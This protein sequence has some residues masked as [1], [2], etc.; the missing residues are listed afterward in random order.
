MEPLFTTKSVFNFEEYKKFNFALSGK[1]TLIAFC[2]LCPIIIVCGIIGHSGLYIALGLIFPLI[3]FLTYKLQLR[4]IYKS[5]K[6]ADKLEPEYKF[7]DT[8]FTVKDIRS[9]ATVQYS[10][11]HKVINTK[12]NVYLMIAKNQGYMLIKSNFPEGLEDFLK[13]ITPKKKH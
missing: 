7:Y 11:L 8:Y 6:L 9:E 13:Q 3:M 2:I 4:K 1:N 5:N 10:M 12:T